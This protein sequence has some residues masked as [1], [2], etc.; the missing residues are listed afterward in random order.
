VTKLILIDVTRLVVRLFTGKKST[1]VDRVSLAYVAHFSRS[2]HAR[3]VLSLG[4]RVVV[5]SERNSGELFEKIL[6]ADHKIIK[7]IY[8]LKWLT[9][10]LTSSANNA[11]FS[12]SLMFNTGHK[13]LDSIAYGRTLVKMGVRPIFFIHDLIPLTHAEYCRPNE[14]VKHKQRITQ[15]IKLGAGLILNSTYTESILQDFAKVHSLQLP[16]TIVSRLSAELPMQSSAQIDLVE[17]APK[18]PYFVMLGTVEPRKNHLMILQIWRNLFEQYG[19]NTPKL[20]V[21]GQRGWEC[22][23]V[24]DAL[25]RSTAVRTHVVENNDCSDTE[26]AG[27]LKGARA[28]LF[29]SFVEGYGIPLV[30]SLQ[31]ATPVIA[32]DI[33]VFREIGQGVPDFINTLD[34]LGWL[35]AIEDY[36][37]EHSAMR[38][39]QLT[40]MASYTHWSWTDHFAVVDAFIGDLDKFNNINNINNINNLNNLNDLSDLSDSESLDTVNNISHVAVAT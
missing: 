38:K 24:I 15:A 8:W 18:L 5:L 4:S 16:A 3:A 40:R 33:P 32:S 21:I 2:I 29:P 9:L 11:S 7:K 19:V 37:Q 1:G 12:T 28:L 36:M 35:N 6:N 39:S 34:G 14:D 26:L 23:Q 30:E 22:E 27:I 17:A 25:E 20:I 10:Y 31:L 13:G